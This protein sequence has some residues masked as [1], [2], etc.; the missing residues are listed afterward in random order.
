MTANDHSKQFM[1]IV[2]REPVTLRSVPAVF[3]KLLLVSALI[4]AASNYAL[5]QEQDT[6]RTAHHSIAR[7]WNEALLDAIRI[8]FARP[9]VHARNLFHSSAAMYDSW[10]LYEHTSSQTPSLYFL[11]ENVR[12]GNTAM[13]QCEFSDN[14]R[15]FW[16]SVAQTDVVKARE[17][18]L[19]FAVY[20]ILQARFANSP[21]A[22][23]TNQRL[24]TLFTT[25]GYDNEDNNYDNVT[26]SS[27]NP[28][29]DPNFNGNPGLVDPNRWQTLQITDFIDQSGQST[30][31]VPA[32]LGAE[33]ANVT[34]F[35]LSANDSSQVIRD[36]TAHTVYLDPGAP[37]LLSDDVE[38]NLAY[39]RG[40]AMVAHWSSHLDPTDGVQWDIS[41]ASMGN[42]PDIPQNNN[43]ILAFYN[44]LDGGTNAQGYDANPITGQA[45]ESTMV[46]RGDFTRVLAEYWADGPDSE[47]PPGHWFDIYNTMISDHSEFTRQWEG[48]GEELDALEF[49][50][51]A[52]F[53]L[54]GAMH[55]SAIAA[56]SIK[57]AYDY[58]RPLSALRYMASLGQSSDITAANYHVH[59]VPLQTDF[60]ETIQSGD[61]LA[62]NGNINVG[63]IKARV[64]RGPS[65]IRNPETDVAGVGW[66]LLENWWPYQRPNFV[67]P[68]FA[69][70]VSGHSTFSRA[71]ADV[72]TAITGS[73]YFPGGLAEFTA[74]KDEFLVFE[75]GPSVDV[76]LQWASYRD[77][78]DQTSLSRIWGGIHPPVDDIPG[79][80]VGSEVAKRAL[81]MS[82]QFFQGEIERPAPI[83]SSVKSGS[84]CSISADAGKRGSTFFWWLMIA[85]TFAL[86]KR[87]QARRS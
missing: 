14:S 69:G 13:P 56:W 11:G 65:L 55:D 31:A 83:N 70:Y 16:Q 33:W 35:A 12:S 41:P 24:D 39:L 4:L 63:R 10:A 42:T 29:L 72:L 73:E 81:E 57:G 78:S 17:T 75:K 74:R 3:V 84:G 23:Y 9:T 71:A 30:G 87:Y 68:P 26:Y 37:A 38:A 79:R 21:G 48:V 43:A 44:T 49:D 20:R 5:A 6:E 15:A 22:F 47:T 28:P 8:D 40:N 58:I 19:S 76:R 61:P 82:Q 36:G 60:I 34:P 51:R 80:R 62:G 32:F 1:Q 25:L 45:Y 85:G 53:A 7:L 59:G 67:T 86:N 52:Y 18:T 77:A 54:G 64:W 66:V 27:V 50:V 2:D 46:P